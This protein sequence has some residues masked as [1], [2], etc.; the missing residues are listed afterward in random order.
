MFSLFLFLFRNLIM[1]PVTKTPLNKNDISNLLDMALENKIPW[2]AL[3]YLLKDTTTYDPKQVI[4]TLLKELEKLHS[5]ML[6]TDPIHEESLAENVEKERFNE[7]ASIKFDETYKVHNDQVDSNISDFHSIKGK[8]KT[9]EDDI[10]ILEMV[11]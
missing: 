5:K 2:N 3:G 10:K 11:E 7:V 6:E 8:S 9:V 4:E 1:K